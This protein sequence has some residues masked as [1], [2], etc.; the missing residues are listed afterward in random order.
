[1]LADGERNIDLVNEWYGIW[2]VKLQDATLKFN[3]EN[4]DL[5]VVL[6][7]IQALIDAFLSDILNDLYLIVTS[8]LMVMTYTVFFL[9]SCSPIHMRTLVGFTG[10]LVTGLS[11]VLGYSVC[12]TLGL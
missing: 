7:T 12:G 8:I 4:E 2:E 9:G 5:R 3:E 10:L 6:F 1:M 11:Y